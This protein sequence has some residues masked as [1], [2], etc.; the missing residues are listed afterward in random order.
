MFNAKKLRVA[1]VEND[2][3]QTLLA[4]ALDMDAR[5]M[6]RRMKYGDFKISEVEQIRQLLNLDIH[7]VAG[8]FLGE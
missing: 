1:M 6:C 3:N 7:A 8:I 5:T 4:K 2:Y